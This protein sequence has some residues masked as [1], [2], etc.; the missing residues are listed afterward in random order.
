MV[1]F[2]LVLTECLLRPVTFGADQ[3][4]LRTYEH[5]YQNDTYR[6]S[7]ALPRGIIAR[8][9]A[10][11]NP[12]H[13]FTIALSVKNE[14]SPVYGPTDSFIWVDGSY[15][16]QDDVQTLADA[17]QFAIRMTQERRDTKVQVESETE[18]SLGGLRAV[19]LTSRVDG[20]GLKVIYQ[21]V[22]AL[23]EFMYTV[24]IQTTQARKADDLKLLDEIISGFRLL[25]AGH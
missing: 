1:L 12:N 11:P 20:R 23:G 25:P 10:P 2:A 13:G 24:G 22:I 15:I 21:R 6:Y 18:I 17:V 3:P 4:K 9:A 14:S 19:R 7:V 5:L 8:G 16:P